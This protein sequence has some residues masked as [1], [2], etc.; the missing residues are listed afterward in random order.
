MTIIGPWTI[1]S[2][3]I[4]YSATPYSILI[5]ATQLNTP[6]THDVPRNVTLTKQAFLSVTKDAETRNKE[7]I[8]RNHVTYSKPHNAT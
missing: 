2:T 1:T 3:E 7:H 6:G 4:P 8:K 5:A